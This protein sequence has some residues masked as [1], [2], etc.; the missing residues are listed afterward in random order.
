MQSSRWFPKAL[1]LCLLLTPALAH[2]QTLAELHVPSEG[3]EIIGF[4][5]QGKKLQ[6]DVPPAFATVKP[7]KCDDSD[8]FLARASNSSFPP[9]STSLIL[10]AN[11]F[12]AERATSTCGNTRRGFQPIQV[13][14]AGE[15]MSAAIVLLPLR[16]CSIE[17]ASG[18]TTSTSILWTVSARRLTTP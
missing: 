14:G 17:I 18:E 10:P 15:R 2:A 5:D 1:V 3:F 6:F 12:H 8:R 7:T 11:P 13:L 9:V 16:S 4:A